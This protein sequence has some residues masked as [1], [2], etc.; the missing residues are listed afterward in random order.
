MASIRKAKGKKE[1]YTIL[2]S[3]EFNEV[4][5]GE[6]SAYDPKDLI[7]RV[8]KA[9]L[10]LL[11]RDARSQNIQVGLEIMDV[12]EK[13]AST[14]LKSYLLSSSYVKRV[15]KVGKS[16]ADDSFIVESKDNVKFKV[17]PL[18]LT[19]YKVQN[20]ILTELRKSVRAEIS[21]YLGKETADKFISEL[22]V[23]KIQRNLKNKLS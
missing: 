13:K 12:K 4:P 8:V 14:R 21:E 17:K 10:G 22:I 15:V 23:K 7:K 6:T 20:K 18:V 5:I 16:K 9:S 19:R 1:W 2:S 3:K 11:T